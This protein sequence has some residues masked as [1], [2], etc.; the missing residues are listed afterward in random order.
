MFGLSKKT[1]MVT[2]EQALPGRDDAAVARWA[3]TSC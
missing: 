1:E 2:A 3:S